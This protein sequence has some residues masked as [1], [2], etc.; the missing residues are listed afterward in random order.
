MNGQE[1]LALPMGNLANR[2]LMTRMGFFNPHSTDY[3]LNLFR[4]VEH[5]VKHYAFTRRSLAMTWLLGSLAVVY[6]SILI[7]RRQLAHPP[8]VGRFLTRVA[9]RYGLDLGFFVSTGMN[10]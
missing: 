4:Y 6:R 10:L 3:I 7:T 8:S 1:V 9:Q 2:Y 5:W